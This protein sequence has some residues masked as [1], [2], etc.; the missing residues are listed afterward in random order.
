ML[1]KLLK[2]DGRDLAKKL[3]PFYGILLLVSVLTRGMTELAKKVELF[4]TIAGFLLVIAILG[5]IGALF[6]TFFASILRF[7]K[8]VMKDEGYLIHTLPIKK[9]SFVISKVLTSTIFMVISVLVVIGAVLIIVP[10]YSIFTTAYNAIVK[11]AG[12]IFNEFLLYILGMSFLGYI[13]GLLFFYCALSLGQTRS[14]KKMTYSFV[15]GIILYIAAQIFSSLTLL[16]AAGIDPI[17]TNGKTSLSDSGQMLAIFGL[18]FA[19][20]IVYIVVSYFITTIT[21][22]K[23]LNL[24]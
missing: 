12:P 17:Y 20:T 8:A 13:S 6:Y 22:E 21:L 4:D 10:D 3:V 7:H 19:I 5:M 16:A 14:D 9:S 18:S 24:E 11:E 23:K 2:Y 1:G 15:Y